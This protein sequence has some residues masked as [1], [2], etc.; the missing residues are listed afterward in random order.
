MDKS[1]Y[2]PL[3]DKHTNADGS[4]NWP[5]FNA[6]AIALGLKQPKGESKPKASKTASPSK[7]NGPVVVSKASTG[8][9]ASGSKP[10]TPREMAPVETPFDDAASVK[11]GISKASTLSGS[12]PATPASIAPVVTP[13]KATPVAEP[14]NVI[15]ARILRDIAS[16]V[17]RG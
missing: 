8:S 5:A 4:V 3:R 16:I 11:A 15:M 2:I 1:V 14:T 13:S 9:K 6:E 12:K 17:E 7:G 10:A